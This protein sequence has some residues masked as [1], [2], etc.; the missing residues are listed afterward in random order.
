MRHCYIN[1]YALISSVDVDGSSSADSGDGTAFFDCLYNG[2]HI[3]RDGFDYKKIISD[4][5]IRRRMGSL[6]KSGVAAGLLCLDGIPSDSVG[7]IVTATGL[8]FLSDT[9]KF[10]NNI[11]DCNESMLNPSPFMQSTFN[12]VGSHIAMIRGIQSYNMTYVHRGFSFES[13]LADGMMLIDEGAETV[14]VGGFDEMTVPVHV[15]LGRL[16]AAPEFQKGEISGFVLL[17]S[18]KTSNT[19]A[20]LHCVKTRYGH[21]SEENLE[22][23]RKDVAVSY[24]TCSGDI[25]IADCNFSVLGPY[26]TDSACSLCNALENGAGKTFIRNDFCGK[27]HS[28]ILLDIL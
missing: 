9:E 1:G 23:W 13:A 28:L 7:G 5:N 14:L 24:G 3:P 22:K 16:G 15:L 27:N 2:S 25:R 18:S 26:M 12:T 20:E 8:G 10:M 6:V 21:F 19:F 11:I 4:G 17:S